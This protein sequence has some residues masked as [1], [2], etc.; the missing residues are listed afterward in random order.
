M[1]VLSSALEGRIEMMRA[2]RDAIARQID[3][4]VPPRDLSSLSR[5]LIEID[6]ELREAETIEEGDDIG[7]AV[8]TPDE[9]FN[10]Y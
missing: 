5:R 8:A 10:P 3:D 1:G 9:A 6:K 2:L 4:G 7:A